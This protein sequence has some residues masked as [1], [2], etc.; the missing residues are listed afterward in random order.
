MEKKTEFLMFETTDGAEVIFPLATIVG[1]RPGPVTVVTA[2]IHGCEYPGI[3]AAIRLFKALDPA[4]LCG[5]V[6]IITLSSVVSF[7]ARRMFVCPVDGKNPNRFF[8]GKADGSYTDQHVYFLMENVISKGDYYIDLHGGDMVEALE[9]FSIYH[10][11]DDAVSQKSYELARYFGLPNIVGTK[12]DG[13]WSDSGTTYANAARLGIPAIIAEAGSVGQLEKKDTQTLLDGLIN[14]LK[15]TG[16]L[17]GTPLEPD[18]LRTYSS[19]TWLY[20]GDHKGI[21]YKAVSPGMTLRAGD[22]VGV[23]E[24]YFGNVL[25]RPVSPVD[26]RVLFV[27]TSPAMAG[28]GLILGIA[29]E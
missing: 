17:E 16:N 6:K 1:A 23:L 18:M 13:A 2:G 27:T 10:A 28:K 29:T 22:Q 9:E 3:A 26:G 7:E 14:V 24:D 21:F 4:A 25:E 5:T 12:A 11:G 15:Y 8:P 20:A 19:M